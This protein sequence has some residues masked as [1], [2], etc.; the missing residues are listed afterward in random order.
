[1]QLQIHFDFF[2]KLSAKYFHRLRCV[3]W[4]QMNVY[5]YVESIWKEHSYELAFKECIEKI[6]VLIS[7]LRLNEEDTHIFVCV[8]VL[9]LWLLLGRNLTVWAI[10]LTVVICSTMVCYN[11]Q[12]LNITLQTKPNKN[13]SKKN[14]FWSTAKTWKN[15]TQ[16]NDQKQR[17]QHDT[18]N[19]T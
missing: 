1:M 4:K 15:K 6:P 16:N 2:W 17:T 18:H 13:T 11:H 10:M 9:V 19:N 8:G 7:V 12:L 14:S 3:W 5:C